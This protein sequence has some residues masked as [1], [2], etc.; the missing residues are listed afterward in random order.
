VESSQA[1]LAELNKFKADVWSPGQAAGA[2]ETVESLLSPLREALERYRKEEEILRYLPHSHMND[3]VDSI[4]NAHTKTFE[5]IFSDCEWPEAD[6]RHTIRFAHWLREGHGAYWVSGKPGSGKSTLM[7]YVAGHQRTKEI[8]SK[9]SKGR[10]AVLAD[11]YFW[12]GGSQ[13]QQTENDLMK[14]LLF[15]IFRSYP[16]LISG[17]FPMNVES[18]RREV[19]PSTKLLHEAFKNMFV[20]NGH[21]TCFCFFI[22]GLDEYN[23]DHHSLIE[24]IKELSRPPNVKVCVASRPWN[25]F[26]DA[27]GQNESQKLYMQHMSSDDIVIYT[28]DY[29]KEMIR[30]DI[31]SLYSNITDMLVSEVVIRAQGVFLWVYLVMRS[32]KEGF[33]NADS[34][35]IL[36]RRLLELPTDLESLFDR[37]LFSVNK[38]YRKEMYAT[39]QVMLQSP[40]PLPLLML[41]FLNDAT[42][43]DSALEIKE[44]LQRITLNTESSATEFESIT[45]RQVNGRYKGLLEIHAFEEIQPIIQFF[46]RTVRDYLQ[47]PDM[48]NKFEQQL[49]NTFNASHTSCNALMALSLAFPNLFCG[50]S[51]EVFMGFASFAQRKR[52]PISNLTLDRLFEALI[53]SSVYKTVRLNKIVVHYGLTD[54]VRHRLSQKT[55]VLE[56]YG[57]KYLAEAITSP[58]LLSYDEESLYEITILL[59]SQGAD[60]NVR[61]HYLSRKKVSTFYLFLRM[62]CYSTTASTLGSWEKVLF[63]F[64]TNGARTNQVLKPLLLGTGQSFYDLMLNLLMRNDTEVL[65]KQN[66]C[67]NLLEIFSLL[68]QHGLNPNTDLTRYSVFEGSIKYMEGSSPWKLL[69]HTLMN[70]KARFQEQM[71]LHAEVMLLF[72][73]HG[74]NPFIGIQARE[75]NCFKKAIGCV[76]LEPEIP[77]PSGLFG[78]IDL[79]QIQLISIQTVRSPGRSSRTNAIEEYLKIREEP[80]INAWMR[81]KAGEQHE[82]LSLD[83]IIRYCFGGTGLEHKLSQELKYQRG[84]QR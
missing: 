67:D 41:P 38:V 20:L 51:M 2:I 74:A 42:T 49:G 59:L 83:D 34:P 15:Q 16:D 23:G 10:R 36:F 25:C 26:E 79:N 72:L 37:L 33:F 82:E 13:N 24:W 61:V 9:W 40:K 57:H 55:M 14:R 63:H 21:Q 22:D 84:T 1:S 69:L 39:F 18:W 65:S 6:P 4:P 7:K 19:K 8:L 11:Y 62:I 60:P 5:W 53:T 77:E 35:T 73:E 54:Y 12:I 58:R 17:L 29:L 71:S 64:L 47:L 44:S 81:D 30:S 52:N 27:F 31:F 56:D 76:Q 68:F 28:R 78:F 3:R 32:L 45:R 80:D 70:C 66:I 46:H 75:W 48:Q 43:A 50:S